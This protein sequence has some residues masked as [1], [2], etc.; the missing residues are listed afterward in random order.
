MFRTSLS[1]LAISAALVSP[2]L[3]TSGVQSGVIYFQGYVYDD[4]AIRDQAQLMSEYATQLAAAQGKNA[5]VG[6]AHMAQSERLLV[7]QYQQQGKT[8]IEVSFI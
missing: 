1:A 6:L 2:A 4:T 3:A 7:K 8:I 5:D